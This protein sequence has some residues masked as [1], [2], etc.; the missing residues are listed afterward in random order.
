MQ[1][2]TFFREE[3]DLKGALL[4]HA[5]ID[6]LCFPTTLTKMIVLSFQFTPL[7]ECNIQS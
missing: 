5:T 2:S 1:K 4:E 6:L 3:K 7:L